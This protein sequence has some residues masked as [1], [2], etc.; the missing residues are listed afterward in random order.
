MTTPGC[1]HRRRCVLVCDQFGRRRIWSS[2]VRW[3]RTWRATMPCGS[4]SSRMRLR[5][6]MTPT[7]PQLTPRRRR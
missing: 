6:V 2:A 1:V 4:K 3:W 5:A 7:I